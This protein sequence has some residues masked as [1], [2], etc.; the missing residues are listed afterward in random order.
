MSKIKKSQQRKSSKTFSK[1]AIPLDKKSFSLFG[2]GIITLVIGFYLMTIPPWDS[3]YA[4]VISPI[5][6]L[7]AY[8]IIFPFGIL[9]TK[10][11]NL[12]KQ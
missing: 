11:N 2:I 1:W 4:L 6:L 12:N 9:K 10:N 7:I 8:L 5:L 3:F